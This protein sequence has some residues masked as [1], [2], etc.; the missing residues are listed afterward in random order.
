MQYRTSYRGYT[1]TP[2]GL[3]SVGVSCHTDLAIAQRFV[4]HNQAFTRT[5]VLAAAHVRASSL[6][7]MPLICITV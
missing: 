5:N 3:L 6:V 2:R 1:W 7:T 4:E